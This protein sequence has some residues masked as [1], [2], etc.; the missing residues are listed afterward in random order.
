VI[1][2]SPYN[3]LMPKQIA[4][5]ATLAKRRW[6]T[7][8]N[9]MTFP[10]QLR[11]AIPDLPTCVGRMLEIASMDGDVSD[12]PLSGRRVRLRFTVK[13][14]GKLAGEFPVVVELQ[15]AAARTLADNLRELAGDAER[16]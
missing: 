3:L 13:E 5:P 8:L 9:T 1:A 10:R 16:Q 11:D 6:S 4:R 14:T 7:S 12:L 15:P 2:E